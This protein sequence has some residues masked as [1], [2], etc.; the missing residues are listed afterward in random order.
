MVQDAAYMV[1]VPDI[2]PETPALK[3]NPVFLYFQDGFQRP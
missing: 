1:A 2:V 3:K